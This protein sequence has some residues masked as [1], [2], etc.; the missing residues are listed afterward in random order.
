MKMWMNKMEDFRY[1]I[2]DKLR[3]GAT[4][5]ETHFYDLMGDNEDMYTFLGTPFELFR[6]L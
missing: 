2:R 3:N 5:E 6:F 1:A 4:L